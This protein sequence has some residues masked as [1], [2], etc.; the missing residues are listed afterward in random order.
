MEY[1]KPKV[2]I[3]LDE[4]QDLLNMKDQ[5]KSSE[6]VNPYKAAIN[7]IFKILTSDPGLSIEFSHFHG[8]TSFMKQKGFLITYYGDDVTI[9]KTELK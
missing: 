7:T 9:I 2:T 1:D 4:Y 6:R 3:D 5:V 8:I